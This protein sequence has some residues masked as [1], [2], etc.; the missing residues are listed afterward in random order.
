MTLLELFETIMKV[1][2][3]L[4]SSFKKKMLSPSR[5][6]MATQAFKLVI[7][8]N[9]E[10]LE[11]FGDSV[12]VVMGFTRYPGQQGPE[13]DVCWKPDGLRYAY[14]MRALEIVRKK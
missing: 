10:H 5:R 14:P 13:V 11:E 7:Q 12:G 3:R 4:T 6:A 2:V 8:G 1:E 9:K